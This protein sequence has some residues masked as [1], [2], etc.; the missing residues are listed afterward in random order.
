M[1]WVVKISLRQEWADIMVDLGQEDD[2]VLTLVGDISHGILQPYAK[3]FPNRYLNV[4]ICEPTIVG[5]AAGSSH[6][7]FIPFVH[8]IAP[9]LIERA[10]EQIKL[11][12][13]YQRL[14]VNL[15]SVGGSF[16]YSQ[17]GCSHHTYADVSMIANIE[18]S[19]V[20]LPGSASELRQLMTA[21]YQRQGI[22]YFRLTENPHDRDLGGAPIKTGKGVIAKHGSDVTVVALGP[23]LRT[24]LDVAE[25]I[26]HHTSVEVIY[27][28]SFKPLDANLIRQSIAKTRAFVTVEELGPYGGLFHSVLQATAGLDYRRSAQLSVNG[29]VSGYGTYEDLKKL[30]GI[31]AANLRDA[32]SEVIS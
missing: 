20:F 16:D 8:T 4:G 1:G 17:L 5:L 31:S 27:I 32:I 14:S 7:G 9:F 11:D 18:G 3:L 29:F 19:Q 12:F 28:H 10:Y 2:R 24:A 21:N 25:E 6:V 13:G 15:I 22:N 26:S 30:A 23:S